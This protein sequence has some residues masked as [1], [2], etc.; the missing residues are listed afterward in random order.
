MKNALLFLALLASANVS[1]TDPHFTSTHMLPSGNC[2]R[3]LPVYD[4]GVRKRPL[5]V[6]NEGATSRYINCTFESVKQK[7][8][9][10]FGVT[11]KNFSQSPQQVTCTGVVGIDGDADYLPRTQT[12][13]SGA[14]RDF[15]WVN[16][17]GWKS[18]TAVQCNVHADGALTYTWITYAR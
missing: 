6:V 7:D 12:V 16:L 1:A 5:G 17:N 18:T 15:Y 11:Y 8:V 13:A 10:D 3:A 4:D 14:S 9:T 2:D